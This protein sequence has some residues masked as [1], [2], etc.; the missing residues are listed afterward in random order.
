MNLGKTIET[1][2]SEDNDLGQLKLIAIFHYLVGAFTILSIGLMALHFKLMSVMMN[3]P[4]AWN[5]TAPG[6]MPAM[7]DEFFKIMVIFYW[8]GGIAAFIAGIL[9]ITSGRSI[10]KLKNRNFS[11]VVAAISC[12]FFPFGTILGVFTLIKLSASTVKSLYINDV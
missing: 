11:M 1:T 12:V 4:D 2:S 9:L 3:N 10:Q 8:I 6:S 7:P 5:Q